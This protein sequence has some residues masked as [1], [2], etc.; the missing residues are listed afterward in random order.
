MATLIQRQSL[1]QLGG[2][3]TLDSVR[4]LDGTSLDQY[5]CAVGVSWV[6]MAEGVIRHSLFLK[7]LK[8][9]PYLLW[10]PCG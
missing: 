2:T 8:S 1:N 7:D 6:G 5:P 4:G 3:L 10:D 9:R